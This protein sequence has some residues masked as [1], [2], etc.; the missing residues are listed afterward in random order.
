MLDQMSTYSA[1]KGMAAAKEVVQSIRYWSNIQWRNSKYAHLKTEFLKKENMEII[2]STAL[3]VLT[4]NPPIY[5]LAAWSVG[6]CDEYCEDVVEAFANKII[7]KRRLR[8]ILRTC[9]LLSRIY[10]DVVEKRYVPG[11]VFETEGSLFWNPLLKANFPPRPTDD[12]I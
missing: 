7:V 2:L 9:A 10:S 6:G 1:P 12:K 11:G 8:G 5:S 3:A 4:K